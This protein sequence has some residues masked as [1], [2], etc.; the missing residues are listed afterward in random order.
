MHPNGSV[1]RGH[2]QYGRL[3]GANNEF[4]ID[5]NLKAAYEAL[6][7]MFEPKKDNQSGPIRP[8]TEEERNMLDN[9]PIVNAI[10]ELPPTHY[11]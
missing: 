7:E 1:W 3:E 6:K 11:S 4:L 2:P 8:L 10:E 5:G 9:Q